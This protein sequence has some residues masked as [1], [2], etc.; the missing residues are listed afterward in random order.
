MTRA[1]GRPGAARRTRRIGLT[2]PIGCGKSTVGRWLVERGAVLVDADEIAREVT[3][4]GTPTHDAVVAHFGPEVGRAD[5]TLDRR[6]LGAIVF[7]DGERLRELEMLVHP[8]VRPVLLARLEAAERAG[9]PV[10]AIEAIRL[11]EAGLAAVCDEV[12]LVRCDP[13]EQRRRLLGRGADP[14]DA[15]RRIAAQAGLAER[16]RPAAARVLDTSGPPD[17][18]R[19]RVD[20]ALDE[21]LAPVT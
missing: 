1:E 5:G 15:E 9:A 14:A 20:A 21:A 3:A 13:D 2:G 8:A 11:V 16:L 7:A 4:P 17:E 18:V 6:A 19:A 12:W 10:V